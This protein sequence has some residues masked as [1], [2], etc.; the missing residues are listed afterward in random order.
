MFWLLGDGVA[1]EAALDDVDGVGNAVLCGAPV[2]L[3]EPV[4]SSVVS[5]LAV[6]ANPLVLDT[7]WLVNICVVSMFSATVVESAGFPVVDSDAACMV[8][9]DGADGKV[10]P[11]AYVDSS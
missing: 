4:T 11:A 6:V 9:L 8:E 7:P 5:T 3:D 10:L 2:G 1:F